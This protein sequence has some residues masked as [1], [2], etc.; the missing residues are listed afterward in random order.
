MVQEAIEEKAAGPLKS[1]NGTWELKSFSAN[2]NTFYRD[3]IAT[4]VKDGYQESAKAAKGPISKEDSIKL[5]RRMDTLLNNVLNLT[6]S[7]SGK[8]YFAERN[9]VSESGSLSFNDKLDQITLYVNMKTDK[10]YTY[11]IESLDARTLVL[12]Q[13]N[14]FGKEMGKFTFAKKS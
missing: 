4:H 9:T 12:V 6:Y 3:K 14:G 2:N 10:M 11:I 13:T 7:F 8:I 5:C 1:L